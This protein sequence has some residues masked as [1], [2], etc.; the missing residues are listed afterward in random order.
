MRRKTLNILILAALLVLTGCSVT[1][2]PAQMPEAAETAHAP[3]AAELTPVPAPEETVSWISATIEY[4]TF[5]EAVSR[6]TDVLVGAYLGQEEAD[7]QK[8]YSFSVEERLKGATEAESICVYA[9]K[10]HVDATEHSGAYVSGE[11][12]Y[13]PGTRYLLILE[14]H[15]S[16][17]YD[18][19]R[20]LQV[21]DVFLPL[22]GGEEPRMYDAPIGDHW[23]CPSPE[24]AADY[25]RQ[26]I[27]EDPTASP[28]VYGTRFIEAKSF[29]EAEE[30]ADLVLRVRVGKLLVTGRGV[31]TE[32]Y[33]CRILECRKGDLDY[34]EG[35][36]DVMVTFPAG[37][38]E[39]DREYWIC[40]NKPDELS[41]IFVPVSAENSIL[42]AAEEQ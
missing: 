7:G 14:R 11:Y 17:Y 1:D 36:L 12:A 25:V 20:Y 30:A 15:R 35:N 13:T 24:R 42:E 4:L 16:V 37:A 22:E 40:V 29:A 28:E 6:C 27:A 2:V 33:A 3:E 39:P 41:R 21:G 5:E 18:E 8:K 10:A 26:L 34:L 23:S 31:P 38:A 32:L 9:E 19:D